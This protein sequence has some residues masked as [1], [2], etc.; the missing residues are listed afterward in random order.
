LES[1]FGDLYE[2]EDSKTALFADIILPV[3]IPKMF[4]Y[5]IPRNLTEEIGIGFRVI[6]QFGKK[7]I[8]TG[9]IGK[10]HQKPPSAYEAKP[11]LDILDNHA[12]VN[13]LQI[14]FWAWMAE[15]YCCHIGEVMNAALPSG[16]KLSSESKIQIN[17]T[18]D[19]DTSPYPLDDREELLLQALANKEEMTYED[20]EVVLGIKS[21]HS[22]IKSLVIKEAILVFEQVKEKYNPVSAWFRLM[23]RIKTNWKLS[24]M[25]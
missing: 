22:I 1:L 23:F 4:T 19:S 2:T 17:P 18:Y 11:I 21:I 20:C 15:Y 25:K 9:I 6:V 7:K 5:K 3:P 13:P 16:L 8:L 12:T 14:R 24:S 10:V